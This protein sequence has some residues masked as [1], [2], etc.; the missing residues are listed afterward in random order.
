LKGRPEEGP[1]EEGE[2][3]PRIAVQKNK[4]KVQL[5]KLG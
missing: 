5:P 1:R 2:G 4:G 3:E